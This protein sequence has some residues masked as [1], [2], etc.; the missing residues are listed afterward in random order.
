MASIDLPAAWREVPVLSG[1]HVRLEPMREAHVD[2]L[3]AALVGDE[4]SKLWFTSVPTADGAGRYVQAALE[5]Q[6]EGRVLPFVVSDADG[7]VV[8]STRFYRLEPEVP[9]LCIGYT[10]YIPRVQRT[11][12]NTEAKRLL[13]THAFET[14]GCLSVVFETSSRNERSRDAIAR[15]GAKQDGILRKHK[16]HADGSVRDT[17]VFSIIDSEWPQVKQDLQARL[18][19]HES[20][21]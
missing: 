18:Q 6:A 4:L 14:M 11:G 20:M 19:Q 21:Q 13:L 7:R 5:A 2:G 16:R 12:V 15:L 9:T 1:S 10:W 17:V 8:G 3:R